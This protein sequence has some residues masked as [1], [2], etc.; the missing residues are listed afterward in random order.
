MIIFL[1]DGKFDYSLHKYKLI[2]FTKLKFISRVL[3]GMSIPTVTAARIYKG[4]KKG[5]TGE[6]ENLTFDKFPYGALSRVKIQIYKN[7]NIK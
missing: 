3:L 4:Q 2:N 7:G 1:G 5:Q 6:E